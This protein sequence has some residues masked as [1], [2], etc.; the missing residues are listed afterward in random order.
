MDQLKFTSVLSKFFIGRLRLLVSYSVI[1]GSIG[2]GL[3]Y[4]TNELFIVGFGSNVPLG[5]KQYIQI[6]LFSLMIFILISTIKRVGKFY[7]Y[8][9][10]LLEMMLSDLCKM[11]DLIQ[12]IEVKK[13]EDIPDIIKDLK[14]QNKIK[15]TIH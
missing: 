12:V 8:F 2:F 15:K 6:G 13:A 4:L 7:I 9:K 5:T 1:L 10:L 11:A 3:L 14:N